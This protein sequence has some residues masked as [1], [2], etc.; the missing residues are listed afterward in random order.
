MYCTNNIFRLGLIPAV[1]QSNPMLYLTKLTE[2]NIVSYLGSSL[3]TQSF[4]YRMM[5]ALQPQLALPCSTHS[6]S[7]RYMHLV[8]G[9]IWILYDLF[10]HLEPYLNY[11]NFLLGLAYFLLR[12]YCEQYK[13]LYCAKSKN[14]LHKIK[15]LYHCNRMILPKNYNLVF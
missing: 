2:A 8:T 11:P 12:H 1:K 9:N 13:I 7:G 10:V 6:N 14:L 5:G 3:D 4:Q 15:F